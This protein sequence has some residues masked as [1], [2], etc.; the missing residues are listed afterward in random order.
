MS[1]KHFVIT[2]TEPYYPGARTTITYNGQ[3]LEGVHSVAFQV[4][5]HDPNTITLTFRGAT[6]E[7]I[8]LPKPEL[9]PV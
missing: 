1:K 3:P 4:V 6:I 9:E 7:F 8:V 2:T 5:A